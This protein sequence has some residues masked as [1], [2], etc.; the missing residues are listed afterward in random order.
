[1][2]HR[3]ERSHPNHLCHCPCPNLA[4]VIRRLLLALLLLAALGSRLVQ[5]VVGVLLLLLILLI[6]I[7]LDGGDSLLTTTGLGLGG[8][9]GGATALDGLGAGGGLGSGGGT[10]GGDELGLGVGPF[11]VFVNE[12]SCSYREGGKSKYDGVQ[13]HL[14]SLDSRVGLVVAGQPGESVL[15][16]GDLV[17]EASVREG[18]GSERLGKSRGLLTLPSMTNRRRT[19]MQVFISASV[20][21]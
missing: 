14:P 7:I 4:R 10:V 8:G 17:K 15:V 3:R 16:D 21:P 20:R 18:L 19:L 11:D 6:V 5:V 1:M 2:Q 13:R 12:T 9:G